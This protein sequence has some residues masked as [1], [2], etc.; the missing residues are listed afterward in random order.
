[1]FQSLC[2]L[3]EVN[4]DYSRLL[5][6]TAVEGLRVED[7]VKQYFEAAEQVLYTQIYI[8]ILTWCYNTSFHLPFLP[9]ILLKSV[10]A[11][12]HRQCSCPS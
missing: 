6:T 12:L 9:C 11:Y 2:F 10:Y 3:D 8:Y 7:L 1:M 4:V 5:K